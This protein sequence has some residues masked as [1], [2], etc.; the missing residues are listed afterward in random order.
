[1]RKWNRS[2][3]QEYVTEFIDYALFHRDKRFYVTA[4]GCGLAGYTPKEIAPMFRRALWSDN[5]FLPE[6]FWIILETP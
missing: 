1:M 2:L 6:E 5:I 3:Y 4:I